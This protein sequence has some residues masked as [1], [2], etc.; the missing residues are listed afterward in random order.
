MRAGQMKCRVEVQSKASNANSYG[1][2]VITWTTVGYRW[3]SIEPLNSKELIEAQ[4]IK[5]ESTHRVKM[6]YDSDITPEHR[7]VFNGRT[8]EINSLIN[9]MELN[10]ELILICRESV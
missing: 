5:S 3:A 7:L 4:Q 6:R 9:V 8:L 10:K 1:E 2:D